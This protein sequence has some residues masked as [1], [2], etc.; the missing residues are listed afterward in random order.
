MIFAFYL[1]LPNILLFFRIMMTEAYLSVEDL[2]KYYGDVTDQIGS[3]SQVK[4][5]STT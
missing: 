5:M 4:L 3:I 2:K 1:K